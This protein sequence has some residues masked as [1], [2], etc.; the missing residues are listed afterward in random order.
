MKHGYYEQ[1][2][3][4]Q[5]QD[6]NLLQRKASKEPGQTQEHGA[7]WIGQPFETLTWLASRAPAGGEGDWEEC[8]CKILGN[9]RAQGNVGRAA[10]RDSAGWPAE[11]LVWVGEETGRSANTRRPQGTGQ[12]G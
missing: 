9:P 12:S 1:Y 2:K 7:M 10:L 11:R 4:A 6:Q 3:P 8:Q 5:R